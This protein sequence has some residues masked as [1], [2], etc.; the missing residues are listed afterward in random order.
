MRSNAAILSSLSLY[1]AG[2]RIV[3]SDPGSA[4]CQSI[5]LPCIQ[6]VLRRR[7]VTCSPLLTD[8]KTNATYMYSRELGVILSSVTGTQKTGGA[9]GLKRIGS[10]VF[11]LT[12][13]WVPLPKGQGEITYQRIGL[14]SDNPFVG[15]NW[16]YMFAP[17]KPRTRTVVII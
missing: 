14:F 5:P 11:G 13:C 1:P 16:E 4:S 2:Y 6:E 10:F 9:S 12:A 15:S 7:Y 17:D 3:I 8:S